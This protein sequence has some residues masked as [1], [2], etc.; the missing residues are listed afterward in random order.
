MD[1]EFEK[2]LI[3]VLNNDDEIVPLIKKY[4]LNSLE[5]IVE[6]REGE[7]SAIIDILSTKKDPDVIDLMSR[8]STIEIELDRL[9]YRLDSLTQSINSMKTAL[10][11]IN[12]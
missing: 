1:T 7:Q 11:N 9:M 10:N 4:L 6:S 5:N 8:V 2:K 12:I 3:E